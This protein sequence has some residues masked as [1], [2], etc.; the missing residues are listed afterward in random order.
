MVRYIAR[1]LLWVV[2][3]LFLVSLLTFVIFYALPSGDPV[4]LR[5]GHVSSPKVVSDIR[6]NLGLD[7]SPL[8]QYWLY[9]KRLVLHFDFGYSYHS[10]V[11]VREEIFERLPATISLAAGAAVIWMIGGVGVGVLSAVRRRKLTDRVAMTG[12]LLAMSAPPYWLGLVVLLLFAQDIG[13]VHL[14]PGAGAYTPLTE[15]PGRWFGALILPWLTLAAGFAAFYARLVRANLIEVMHE[16]YIRTA[17]AKGV[18]ERQVVLR[19]GLR[20]AI[21]PVITALGLDIGLLLGGTILIERVFDVPGIGLL[22][23]QSIADADLPTI[24][25]T[26][27]LG[28][29]FIVLANLVVDVAYAFLDPRVRYS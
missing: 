19:H 3:L 10:A 17:R 9:M 7:R 12:A 28:A 23:Y 16:D 22:A 25:G 6:H 2:L 29:F 14:F 27:L 24:Q 15:D 20:S 4:T 11:P 1:R 8:T 26:V 18:P 21:T 13:Q 5:A